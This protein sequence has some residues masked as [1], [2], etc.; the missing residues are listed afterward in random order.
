MPKYM[1][2]AVVILTFMFDLYGILRINKRFQRQG[3]KEQLDQ[4]RQ[5][6][7]SRIGV[8]RDFIGF[9]EKMTMFVYFSISAS[10]N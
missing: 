2:F 4:I 5:W 3:L 10:L 6:K 1:V 8:F 7:N 9:Y